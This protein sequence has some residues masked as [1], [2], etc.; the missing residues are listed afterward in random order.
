MNARKVHKSATR[1]SKRAGGEKMRFSDL[2]AE[3]L[4]HR[5]VEQQRT[6]PLLDL[7]GDCATD[8]M[9]PL[10]IDEKLGSVS[11]RSAFTIRNYRRALS[12]VFRYGVK[13]GRIK[14]NP[15]VSI[16]GAAERI[17]WLAGEKPLSSRK[18]SLNSGTRS[19]Q[20][21]LERKPSGTATKQSRRRSARTGSRSASPGS[22]FHRPAAR[23]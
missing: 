2:I 1:I 5:E 17:G 12:S 23:G 22:R 19:R 21:A 9:T 4:A 14:E 11:G 13:A 10:F 8:E 7:F 3:A 6:G 20:T 15:A 16:R 18:D